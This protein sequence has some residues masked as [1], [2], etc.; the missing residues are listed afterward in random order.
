MMPSR[1]MWVLVLSAAVLAGGCKDARWDWWRKDAKGGKTQEKSKVDAKTN[2]EG[3]DM[4]LLDQVAP[5]S[6]KTATRPTTTTSAPAS[7]SEWAKG[8]PTT[9]PAPGRRATTRRAEGPTIDTPILQVND[10]SISVKD[11]VEPLRADLERASKEMSM[12]EYQKFAEQKLMIRVIRLI[13]ELLAYG[14]AKKEVTDEM[15]VAIK[16]A[17]DQTEQSRIQAEFGGR[18][19][20]YEAWLQAN[21]ENREDVR[22]RIR[23]EL[24]VRRFLHDKFLPLIR[25]PTRQEMWK[26]YQRHP[27]E[28][29]EPLRVEM[30]LVDIPYWSFLEGTPADDRQAMWSKVSGPRRLEA[31]RAA[32]RHAEQALQE[33]RSGIPYD[34]IARSYSRGPN[35]DK[36]GAWGVISPGGLTGR[37]AEVAEVL[38]QLKADQ[39]SDIMKTDDGL[40][41][42][43]AGQ[44]SEERT[45]PFSEAQVTIERDLVKQQ[46]DK[47][48]GDFINKL[49][50]KATMGDIGSFLKSVKEAIPKQAGYK[51][52]YRPEDLRPR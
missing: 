47:L 31:R 43:K 46:Q 44:R 49:R 10:E 39:I 26:Y 11:V 3:L 33:L 27:K 22:S 20:R 30:F 18:F 13:D 5:T 40:F 7:R 24:L 34:A 50:N 4:E 16:K 37:W 48:E 9:A 19:S 2:T 42:V 28:F 36:G 29:V 17:V 12:T 52:D 25:H 45:I 1:F 51:L 15:E 23:R 41:I 35:A 32:Q 6:Q 38:F 8:K 14:E 21:G